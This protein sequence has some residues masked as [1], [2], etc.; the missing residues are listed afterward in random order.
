MVIKTIIRD[1]T[2]KEMEEAKKRQE[3]KSKAEKEKPK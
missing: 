1:A 2:P 3:K